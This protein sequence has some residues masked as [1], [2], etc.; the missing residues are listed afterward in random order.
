V[1]SGGECHA[2]GDGGREGYAG[3]GEDCDVAAT[4]TDFCCVGGQ[5]KCDGLAGGSSFCE[6]KGRFRDQGVRRAWIT[7]MIVGGFLRP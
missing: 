2:R 6:I 4:D 7:S 3:F 5:V 1:A